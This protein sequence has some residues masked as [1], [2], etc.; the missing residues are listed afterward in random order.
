MEYKKCI[1]IKRDIENWMIV[2]HDE[3]NCVVW[4]RKCHSAWKTQ[5]QYVAELQDYAPGDQTG[6]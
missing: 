4:C 1:C 6:E 5:A 3:I 2:R